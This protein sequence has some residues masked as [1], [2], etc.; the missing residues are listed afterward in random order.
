M[1]WSLVQPQEHFFGSS[2]SE[3]PSANFMADMDVDARPMFPSTLDP[4]AAQPN[5]APARCGSPYLPESA[6]EDPLP[7]Q[8]SPGHSTSSMSSMNFSATRSEKSVMLRTCCGLSQ[9]MEYRFSLSCFSWNMSPMPMAVTVTS[10]LHSA[11]R[12]RSSSRGS[13][14]PSVMTTANTRV[15]W[16]RLSLMSLL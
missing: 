2:L 1:A 14:R 13:W 6:P 7:G 9:A 3:S 12:L 15:F 5:L 16:R 4:P 8:D 11:R 10:W